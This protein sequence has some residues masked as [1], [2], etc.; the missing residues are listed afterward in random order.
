M[1]IY[2]KKKLMIKYMLYDRKVY[3]SQ[4]FAKNWHYNITKKKVWNL[5]LILQTIINPNL[6]WK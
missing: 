4:Y 3:Y 1:N 6:K 2:Y 5:Q